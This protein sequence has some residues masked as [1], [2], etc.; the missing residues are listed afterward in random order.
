MAQADVLEVLRTF[1][2]APKVVDIRQPQRKRSVFKDAS[3]A[4]LE[5]LVVLERSQRA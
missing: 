3:A 4:A 2:G 5:T 1:A